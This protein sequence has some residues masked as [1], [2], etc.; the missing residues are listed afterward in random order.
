MGESL[1]LRPCIPAGW[2]EYG[3]TYRHGRS[4]YDIVVTNP[5]GMSCGP[6]AITLDG[7]L[8]DPPVIPLVDDGARHA[9]SVRM[10]AQPRDR[11]P[12]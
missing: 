12:A 8:L 2:P 3:I 4:H 10:T 7:K 1:S 6:V 11:P 9:V 5:D